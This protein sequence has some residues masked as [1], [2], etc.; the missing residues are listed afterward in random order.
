MGVAVLAIK[1]YAVFLTADSKI[2]PPARIAGAI[3]DANAAFNV[4]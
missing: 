3:I 1:I 2:E 4:P